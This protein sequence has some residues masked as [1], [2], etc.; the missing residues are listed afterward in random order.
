MQTST[1]IA[2]LR[3]L[4]SQPPTPALW[5]DL[6]QLLAATRDLA[7]QEWLSPW[8]QQH[9]QTWPTSC[10]CIDE[11]FLS[12]LSGVSIADLAPLFPFT[13]RL[14]LSAAKEWGPWL[15]R[16]LWNCL[17]NFD[18]S[19][20]ES[21]DTLS[22][23][24]DV[25]FIPQLRSLAWRHNQMQATEIQRL[26][27]LF[28]SMPRLEILALQHNQLEDMGLESIARFGPPVGLRHLYVEYNELSQDF[29]DFVIE[30]FFEDTRWK[31]VLI[32]LEE[33]MYAGMGRSG[34]L[35]KT[36]G[37]SMQ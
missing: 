18:W 25:S 34:P 28:S 29:Y 3:H 33:M 9:L 35:Q 10:R 30:P 22:L 24:E 37:F 19:K 4:F 6:A 1:Q 21:K 27:V 13:S 36:I 8:L 2:S 17:E 32:H 11:D 15:K 16:P 31:K 20:D 14:Q 5:L 7:T 12:S 23:L 26:L